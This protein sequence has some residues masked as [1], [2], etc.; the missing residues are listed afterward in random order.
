MHWY[1]YICVYFYIEVEFQKKCWECSVLS[2]MMYFRRK[3]YRQTESQKEQD[4]ESAWVS[5]M[6]VT[7]CSVRQNRLNNKEP[8]LKQ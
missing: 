2:V 6:L 3:M 8:D 4:P 1:L 5:E 7:H